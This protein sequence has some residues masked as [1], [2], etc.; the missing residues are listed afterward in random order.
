MLADEEGAEF[1]S[2]GTDAQER[3]YQ[4]AKAL[5]RAAD[6]AAGG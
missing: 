6:G 2:L 3:Y 5:L 4:A 1:G